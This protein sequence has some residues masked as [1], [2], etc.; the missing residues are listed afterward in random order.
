MNHTQH[1]AIQIGNLSVEL[2][3]YKERVDELEA[4][5]RKLEDDLHVPRDV[6]GGALPGELAVPVGVR[7]Q[8]AALDVEAVEPEVL[9]TPYPVLA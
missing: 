4:L 9:D 7:G 1:L 5:V 6:T 8:D 2:A 3:S